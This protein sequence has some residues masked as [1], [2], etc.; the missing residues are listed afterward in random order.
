MKN[1]VTGVM[2]LVVVGLSA[3]CLKGGDDGCPDVGGTWTITQHCEPGFVGAVTEISVSGCNI[4][5][6]S[7]WDSWT[8]SVESDGT[9]A[10][11][12][13]GG[14]EFITCSGTVFGDTISVSC[15]GDGD[16]TSCVVSL[17]RGGVALASGTKICAGGAECSGLDCEHIINEVLG[18][19]VTHCT[20]ASDCGLDYHCVVGKTIGL[21]ASCFEDCANS[22]CSNGYQ[23]LEYDKGSFACLPTS[24]FD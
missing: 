9:L 10:M 24:W 12:G 8:G 2:V 19:C 5:D 20:Q 17:S 1:L 22:G 11:S 7:V 16:T 18:A 13:Y 23:C 6:V 21:E 4:T 14:G 3:G 15:D